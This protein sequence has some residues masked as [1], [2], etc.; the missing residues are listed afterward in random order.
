MIYGRQ[1][2]NAMKS[3]QKLLIFE[4]MNEHELMVMMETIF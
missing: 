2:F 3:E 4:S 1:N